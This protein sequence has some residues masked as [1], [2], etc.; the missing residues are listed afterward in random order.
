MSEN[1]V[2]FWLNRRAMG[3]VAAALAGAALVGG[4]GAAA[5]VD[6]TTARTSAGC[7]FANDAERA[8]NIQ[9]CTVPSAAMGSTVTVKV[10]PSTQSAGQQEQAVYL[11]GG[12]TST[13]DTLASGYG[14]KYNLV[15]V[16]GSSNAWTS[17]WVA[18]PRDSNGHTLVN[19]TGGTYNPRWETFIGTEL[20]KYLNENFDIDE[21]DNAIV[22]LS[23]NGGQAVNIALKYP[24]LFKVALSVSGYYQTDNPLGYFLV[25][26][27]LKTRTG[28]SNALNDMWGSPFAPGNTWAENDVTNRIGLSK[29]NGQTII[30]TAGNGIITSKE[31]FDEL[32]SH[33]G[34]QEVVA[35]VALEQ[36]SYVSAHLL[37]FVAALV[38]APVQ[39]IYNNGT[40]SWLNWGAHTD[41]YAD[42]VEAGLE[43]YQKTPPSTA[44]RVAQPPVA[45]EATVQAAPTSTAVTSATAETKSYAV[46]VPADVATGAAP[47]PSSDTAGSSSV[48][49][50]NT[51]ESEPK[52]VEAGG[53]TPV[54]TPVPGSDTSTEKVGDVVSPPVDHSSESTPAETAASEKAT[55]SATAP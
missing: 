38:G 46:T 42:Q 22:G 34:L 50:A 17:D 52:D 45:H 20:P 24:T 31:E 15:M 13:S 4:T 9:T 1:T 27:A 23:E 25:P 10:R 39:G 32:F 35:G 36:L 40:H 51:S 26:Y 37:Q 44:S 5:A 7:Y 19:Q 48:P 14:D 47:A 54:E 18:P 3:V 55:P 6:P 30:V 41:E 49:V 12:I 16:E 11:L 43:K 2:H 28:V 21:T 53:A 29:D 8:Q 33:G